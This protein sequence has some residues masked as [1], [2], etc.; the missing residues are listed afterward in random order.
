MQPSPFLHAI[1]NHTSHL[2]EFALREF[3]NKHLHIG[4]TAVA[5][6]VVELR[7]SADEDELIAVLAQWE[8]LF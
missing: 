6:A 7:E 4:Q 8:A 5:I 1:H 3:L 2:G